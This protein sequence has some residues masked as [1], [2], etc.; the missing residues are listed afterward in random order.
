[1]T[2]EGPF[3]DSPVLGILADA[4]GD[5]EDTRIRNENRLRQLTSDDD[6]GHGL[7]VDHPDV[8]RLSAIV[9]AMK[10]AENDAV[11]GIQK[12]MRQ[13]PLWPWAKDVIGLG[14]KQFARLLTSIGDPY[15]NDLHNRPRTVSELWAYS[16]YHVL[17]AQG[18]S[19]THRRTGGVAP[20]HKR[21]VQANWSEEARKRCWLIANSLVK[22]KHRGGKYGQVYDA[23][24]AK[25]AEAVHTSVCIRC[26]PSGKPAQPGSP[27][28]PGHQ[29]A[30][31]LRAVSKELLKDLWLESR[32]LHGDEPQTVAA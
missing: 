20:T 3:L 7:N 19:D 6:W 14:E 1:M 26:G 24:R 4:L 21:G 25:Y 9:D 16:G 23:T 31:G 8:A 5:L 2:T 28:S 11:K 30:R 22:A 15:W 17:P 27:L 13:H 29:H 32:R 12:A 18:S 10:K